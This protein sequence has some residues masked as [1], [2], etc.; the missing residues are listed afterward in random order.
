MP[1]FLETVEMDAT[2]Q[3][4][5]HPCNLQ[6]LG[7]HYHTSHHICP[8]LPSGRRHLPCRKK[9]WPLTYSVVGPL[10]ALPWAPGSGYAKVGNRLCF[11]DYGAGSM[12]C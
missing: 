5:D 4:A 9:S 8:C 10:Q 12:D 6:H 7:L 1:I 2:A 11:G 3:K